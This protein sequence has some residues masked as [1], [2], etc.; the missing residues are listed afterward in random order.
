MS[1]DLADLQ[2][3]SVSEKL[4]IVETLWDDIGASDGPVVLHPW[5]KEEAF[6]RSE[7]L[8]NDP[9]IAIDRA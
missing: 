6:R 3:L 9:S 5:Q 7:D 8:K 1:I 4:R 2:N